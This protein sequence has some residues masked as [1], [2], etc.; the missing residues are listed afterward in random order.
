MIQG[1]EVFVFT[2]EVK[3]DDVSSA[4]KQFQPHK[5][6]SDTFSTI[7]VEPI[8]GNLI[9]FEKHWDDYLV[10]DGIRK[11]TVEKGWKRTSEY[12][13]YILADATKTKIEYINLYKVTLPILISSIIAVIGTT[14]I[15][16]R[17]LAIAKREVIR[18]E[19]LALIGELTSRLS[20]DLRNPLAVIKG[21]LDLM[22]NFPNEDEKKR[23]ER[24]NNINDAI[25]RI[26]YQINNIMNYIKTRSLQF[27]KTSIWKILDSALL[28][29]K[30][31]DTVQ[32]EKYGNDVEVECDFQALRIVFI[33]L[34]INA[35]Q[36]IE[37]KGRI[38]I[39]LVAKNGY[40]EIKIE[41]SGPGMSDSIADKIFEPLF[42]TKQEGTGLGLVSCKN[43]IEQHGGTISVSNNPTTFTI[44]IPKNQARK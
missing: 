41:D 23:H 24:L 3:G 32:F 39:K 14:L 1:L 43:I 44:K 27:E 9:R 25:Y 6:G 17:K 15:L 5:I 29:I 42:T 35:I 13:E 38:T 33:N 16:Q 26:S 30:I 10:E 40:A 4:F 31:P 7:W 11:N 18:T 22:T 19:K 37:E 12:S 36:A 20:H 34:I 21:N 2:A 8:T 28:D